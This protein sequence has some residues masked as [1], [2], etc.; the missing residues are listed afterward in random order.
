MNVREEVARI[1]DPQ[2]FA[3]SISKHYG[4]RDRQQEARDKADAIL[5]LSVK[6]DGS[7]DIAR[8]ALEMRN[9][10]DQIEAALMGFG[11]L[12]DL[13]RHWSGVSKDRRDIVH[14]PWSV[15][16]AQ[17]FRVCD[18]LAE[19]TRIINSDEYDPAAFSVKP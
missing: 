18:A 13:P 6:T 3:V 2:A 7:E 4:I 14:L 10:I 16:I 5:A 8:K 1:I 15:S 17:V 12:V 19:C 9:A 11:D